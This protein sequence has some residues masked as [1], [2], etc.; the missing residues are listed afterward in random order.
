MKTQTEYGIRSFEPDERATIDLGLWAPAWE[1][2]PHRGAG[3][4]ERFEEGL[5]DDD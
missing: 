2:H 3:E 1:L 5:D 4:G